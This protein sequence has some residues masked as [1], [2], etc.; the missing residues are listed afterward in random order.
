MVMDTIYQTT[1]P[2]K[3]TCDYLDFLTNKVFALLPM[4]EES[5]ISEK[6]K[7]SHI[8]YQKN[9]IQTI[10]GN[11][12]LIKYDSYIVVDILSHLQSLFEI[13]DHD[14]YKRHVFKVCSLLSQL[15]K[16]VADNGI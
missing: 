11:T 16:E 6:K 15:K 8:I 13:S 10:N 5:S 12:E 4:F 7:N 2:D 1:I 3:L 9:L 14:D